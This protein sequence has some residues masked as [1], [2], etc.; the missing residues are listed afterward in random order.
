MSAGD[1]TALLSEVAWLQARVEE[2]ESAIADEREACAK[3]IESHAC[4]RNPC[5]ATECVCARDW[6]TEIRRRDR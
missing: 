1:V 5:G 2:L 3:L 4:N 6:A